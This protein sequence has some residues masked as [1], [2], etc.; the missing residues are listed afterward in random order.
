MVTDW[1]TSVG[2]DTNITEF[3][4]KADLTLPFTLR[5]DVSLLQTFFFLITC[6]HF[7]L[8]NEEHL[9]CPVEFAKLTVT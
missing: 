4:F 2:L 6:K 7:E 9:W 3:C 8:T 1:V 5:P